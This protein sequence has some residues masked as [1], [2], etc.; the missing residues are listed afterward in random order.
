MAIEN[1]I[2]V[3][4][5]EGPKYA[6]ALEAH[7]GNYEIDVIK[8]RVATELIPA[9]EPGGLHTVRFGDDAA[10]RAHE[11]IIATGAHWRLMG[12]PGEQEYRNKG[13]TFCPH[14]DGPLFKGK[15]IAVIGG[16]NSGI[17]AAIDLAGLA[18]HVTVLEFMPQCLADE[19]LMDKLNSMP[20]VDVITNAQTTE[21]L[22][23]GEQVTGIS[24][25]DRAS[26]ETGQLA[27]SGV[28]VQ[29]GLVPNTDWLAGTLEL[30][31]RKEIVTD[32]R[33]LTAVEGIYAAGDCSTEPYKQI[34]VAQ[35]SGAIAALSAW[36]HLIRQQT[37]LAS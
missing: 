20:N 24:Y 15:D 31:P 5:T 34:V 27:L 13:I 17:E 16:G 21:V 25:R 1:F 35:G 23:D 30:S 2:S 22:G 10:L 37:V 9:T 26:G 4:Y 11:V 36:E 8:S 32:R 28:F 14:C 12:V 29:I 3:P 18:S 7:V 6:A 33:G 19:V